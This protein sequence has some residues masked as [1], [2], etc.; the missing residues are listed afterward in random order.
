M[1]TTY[2]QWL[3]LAAVV[4]SY[5]WLKQILEVCKP[6]TCKLLYENHHH[7]LTLLFNL[8][9]QMLSMNCMQV[10][11]NMFQGNSRSTTVTLP[12]LPSFLLSLCK[13]NS[14]NNIQSYKLTINKLNVFVEN[15]IDID[16]IDSLHMT[17]HLVSRGTMYIVMNF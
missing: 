11:H 14:V 5:V 15:D 1:K 13:L 12:L 16:D 8:C 4:L 2:S 17:S 10:L 9:V 7:Y 3:T 6:H